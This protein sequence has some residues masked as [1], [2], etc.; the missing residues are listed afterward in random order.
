MTRGRTDC[1]QFRKSSYRKQNI[2]KKSGTLVGLKKIS[3]FILKTEPICRHSKRLDILPET[4]KLQVITFLLTI[5]ATFLMLFKNLITRN[6][7]FLSF[8]YLET[9]KKGR[10]SENSSHI[11]EENEE[12][13][14]RLFFDIR[15]TYHR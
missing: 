3:S 1:K 7:S 11:T 9:K 6:I 12:R 8:F 13:L 5:S 14:F 10:D 4:F 2:F 15:N